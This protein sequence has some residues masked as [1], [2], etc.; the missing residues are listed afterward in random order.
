M[1]ATEP[2]VTL[3]KFDLKKNASYK[4]RQCL[5]RANFWKFTENQFI[6]IELISLLTIIDIK[7]QII[8]KIGTKEIMI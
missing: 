4:V 3:V 1:T 5:K 2:I 6:D 7:R 8:E